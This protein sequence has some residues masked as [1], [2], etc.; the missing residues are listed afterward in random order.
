MWVISEEDREALVKLRDILK[1]YN[2]KTDAETVKLLTVV[3]SNIKKM[4]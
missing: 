2:W 3:L 4:D 1:K